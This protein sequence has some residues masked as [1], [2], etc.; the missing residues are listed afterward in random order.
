MEYPRWTNELLD[1]ARCKGD[2]LADDAIAAIF[3]EGN[4]EAVNQI[5]RLMVENDEMPQEGFARIL[6]GAC[7]A[8]HDYRAVAFIRSLHDSVDLFKVVYIECGQAV[9]IFRRVIQKLTQ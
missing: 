5:M 1:A 7:G 3:E 8:L 6:A 4:L 9:A 2:P